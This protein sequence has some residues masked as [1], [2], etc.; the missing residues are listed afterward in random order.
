MYPWN[1]AQRYLVVTMQRSSDVVLINDAL[2]FSIAAAGPGSAVY[3][4][5]LCQIVGRADKWLAMGFEPK[6]GW[7]P[8]CFSREEHGELMAELEGHA[9]RLDPASCFVWDAALTDVI[10]ADVPEPQRLNMLV[11]RIV[12]RH[13]VTRTAIAERLNLRRQTL[14]EYCDGKTTGT[15][16]ATL[17]LALEALLA[18]PTE[19]W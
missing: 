6:N 16:G 14:Q 18:R 8:W 2:V 4:V 10:H 15:M 7:A 12:A 1:I 11:E 13:G 17:T 19:W 3:K 5:E 9:Y